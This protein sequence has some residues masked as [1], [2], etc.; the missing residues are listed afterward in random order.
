MI[1]NKGICCVVLCLQCCDKKVGVHFVVGKHVTLLDNED[2]TTIIIQ[3]V[4]D[5]EATVSKNSS[6]IAE[7]S[8]WSR[9]HGMKLFVSTTF[10]LG[11]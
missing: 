4:E 7:S 6:V 10:Y 11:T 8:K 9:H 1:D 2:C 3:Q 5:T